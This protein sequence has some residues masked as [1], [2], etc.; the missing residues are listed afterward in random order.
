MGADRPEIGLPLNSAFTPPYDNKQ[1]L[2]LINGTQLGHY[3]RNLIL[4]GLL[5][6]G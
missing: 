1:A 2:I 4:S 5:R 6:G 3:A